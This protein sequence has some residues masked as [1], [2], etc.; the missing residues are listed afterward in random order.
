MKVQ[1]YT[2]EQAVNNIE[3][4]AKD[5]TRLQNKIH[6]TAVALLKHWHDNPTAGQEVAGHINNLLEASPYHRR[7]FSIWLGATVDITDKKKKELVSTRLVPMRFSEETKV[8]YVHKDDKITGKQFMAA[9]DNPFYTIA[10]APE[11]KP[12]DLAASFEALL[13]KADK[14]VKEA[15]EGDV[16]NLEMVKE[17]KAIADKY[18]QAA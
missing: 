16:I 3:A 18:R 13:K 12:L 11:A 10:P 7:A 6:A 8:W 15:V 5:A 14:H 4:I 1:A 2:Y 9:R 17:M